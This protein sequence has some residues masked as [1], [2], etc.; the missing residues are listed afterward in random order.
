MNWPTARTAASLALAAWLSFAVAASLHVQHAYWAAMPVW[1][2]TQPS[3]GQVL[4]RA[5]FR[6]LGTLIGALVGFAL[7]RLPIPPLAH[8]AVLALWIAINAGLTHVLR[9]VL[10]YA[11][12]L[13]GITAAI[14]IIPS[15]LTPAAP[16]DLAV[17]RVECTLIGVTIS[18]LVL[19]LLTPASPLT[20]FYARIRG[21][22][23]EAVAYAAQVLRD[24]QAADGKCADERR[25]LA[26]ISQLESTARLT[27]AGSVEGYRHIGDVD[28]LVVGSLSAMAAAQAACA[29]GCPCNTGLP[30]RLDI[31]AA[32]LR[33]D[34]QQPVGDAGRHLD[35]GNDP[36]GQRLQLAID[37]ILAADIALQRPLAN[38]TSSPASPTLRLAPHR[39]WMLARRTGAMAGLST[40]V[41]AALG[42][43]WPSPPL[44][45]AA[46]GVCI[47]VMVLS[48]STKFL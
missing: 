22:A 48:K 44:A 24:G 29:A 14:V 30:A 16:T 34:R 15:V 45:L 25:I 40:L 43:W 32:D 27:S 31:L 20:E 7:L 39:E 10:G 26:M 18:A 17:A 3:R 37:Q 21:V 11:A 4:E 42:L 38:A 33:N 47:F 35:A 46:M 1:V 8:I 19:A 2:L 23:A 6:L 36:A 28:L 12:L 5:A 13:A 9:G 41:A